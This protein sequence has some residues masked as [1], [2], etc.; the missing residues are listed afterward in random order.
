MS[1]GRAIQAHLLCERIDLTTEYTW[2]APFPLRAACLNIYRCLPWVAAHAKESCKLLI[3]FERHSNGINQTLYCTSN[4]CHYLSL[5]FNR[6]SPSVPS[7]VPLRACV[8]LPV[9][10]VLRSPSK[11]ESCSRAYAFGL[12]ALLRE[13]RVL[14]I[15]RRTWTYI[16]VVTTLSLCFLV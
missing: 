15:R 13:Y 10:F 2:S 1:S 11:S 8:L 7:S 9:P 5:V 14:I 16:H 3:R 4:Y 12:S 6:G